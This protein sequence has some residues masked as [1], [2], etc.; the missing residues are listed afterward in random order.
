MLELLPGM[1]KDLVP[2]PLWEKQN[3][4]NGNR[5]ESSLITGGISYVGACLS[6]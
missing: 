2:S 3:R 4:A 6:L 5:K 1:H